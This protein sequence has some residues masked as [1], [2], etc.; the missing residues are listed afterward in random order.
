LS[1]AKASGAKRILGL[2]EVRPG[3]AAV[4]AFAAAYCFFLMAANSVLKPYREALGTKVPGL[5]GLWFGTLVACVLVLPPYWSLVGRLPRQRFIPWVHRFFEVAFVTFFFLL[6]DEQ[7]RLFPYAARAFYAGF[8]A[9][10]LL[11]IA[12]FWG[13]MSDVFTRDQA[14]RLFAWIMAGG[15]I[16]GMLASYA[17]TWTTGLEGFTPSALVW[18]T[19]VLLELASFAAVAIARHA[20]PSSWRPPPRSDLASRLADVTGGAIAFARSPYLL[21]I[22]GFMFVSLFANA[23]VYDFQRV[24]VRNAPELAASAAKTDYFNRINLWQQGIALVG[25]LV[26]TSRLLSFAK[27]AVTLATLPFCAAAGLATFALQPT[28]AVIR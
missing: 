16:G 12:Q 11:V 23:F 26:V 17:I 5:S 7:T 27:L 25:Q 10:N 14:Q 3:E 20:A 22:A 4:V 18:P 15:T 19:I 8:S 1:E 13:F 9:F 2:V 24:M 21:A 28:L 6:R